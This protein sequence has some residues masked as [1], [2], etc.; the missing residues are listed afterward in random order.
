M[1]NHF[2]SASDN[3]VN[4]SFPIEMYYNYFVVSNINN[5]NVTQIVLLYCLILATHFALENEWH[6]CK[7]ISNNSPYILYRLL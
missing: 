5:V 2:I 4:K 1:W 7:N 3:I 6:L